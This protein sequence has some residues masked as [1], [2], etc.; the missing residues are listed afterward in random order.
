[1]KIFLIDLNRR[2]TLHP[3]LTHP[4][5]PVTPEAAQRTYLL[6]KRTQTSK[7]FVWPPPKKPSG[8]R[9]QEWV[10]SSLGFYKLD[11]G[12]IGDNKRDYSVTMY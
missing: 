3:N 11:S 12:K 4:E 6:L 10:N 7:H 8:H 9:K 1:M 5:Y 2:R